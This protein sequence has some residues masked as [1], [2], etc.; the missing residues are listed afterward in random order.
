MT[1]AEKVQP[2]VL[3]AEMEFLIFSAA[4]IKM[5]VDTGQVDCIMGFHQAEQQGVSSFGLS[6]ILGLANETAPEPS[7]VILYRNGSGVCG[8]GIDRLDEIASVPIETIQPLPQPLSYFAG[9][10]IF[11]GVVL[12]GNDAVLLIDLYRLKSLKPCEAVP[13]A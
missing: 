9:P 5:A 12:R 11:W 10:R 1:D 7:T 2:C 6:E 13:T 4:G 3:P 8:L